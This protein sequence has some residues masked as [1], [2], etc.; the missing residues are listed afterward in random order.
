MSKGILFG[1]VLYCLAISS[2]CWGEIQHDTIALNKS[3]SEYILYKNATLLIDTTNTIKPEELIT[4][5]IASKFSHVDPT[6]NNLKATHWLRFTLHNQTPEYDR[7]LM[8]LVDPHIGEFEFFEFANGTFTSLANAGFYRPFQDKNYLHKNFVIEANFRQSAYKTYYVRLKSKNQNSFNVFVRKS[9]TLFGYALREYYLLGLFYGVL[10]VMALYN[11]FLFFSIRENTYLYYVIYIIS[12]ALVS[13]SEDGIGF[14]YL[15]PG[16]PSL[17]LLIGFWNP[18]FFMV[19]FVIY[20]GSFLRLNERLPQWNKVIWLATALYAVVFLGQTLFREHPKIY[21]PI[22]LVPFGLVYLAGI[23]SVFQGRKAARYF[24]LAYSFILVSIFITFLRTNGWGDVGFLAVYSFNFGFFFEVL[25]LSYAMS[26]RFKEE[27]LRREAAQKEIIRQLQER[28]KYQEK[29]NRDL[30]TR[31]QERTAELAEANDE[32]T[33]MNEILSE[34]NLALQNNVKQISL[35]R[36]SQ[37]EISFEEFCKSY[38]DEQACYDYLASL[39]WHNGYTCKKCGNEKYNAISSHSRRC[40]KCKYIESVTAYTIFHSIK[41]SILHAFYMLFLINLRK[42][43][44]VEEL[45]TVVPLSEKS[46]GSFKRK[47]MAAEKSVRGRSKGG[48]ER[49]IFYYEKED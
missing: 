21:M 5:A 35:E 20:A 26:E 27:K 14:Q 18:L 10:L 28:E 47:V 31:V 7:W 23:Y 9:D 45:A 29:L 44:K 43:I 40:N 39:K 19:I 30:E 37:Q 25:I 12:C 15:W 17:N 1:L 36:I 46:C 16:L 22:Y 8:E 49:L 11:L 41:F 4:P 13:F 42:D 33:R 3:Q 6:N 32:I 38:P 2:T 34:H 48:W 24:V